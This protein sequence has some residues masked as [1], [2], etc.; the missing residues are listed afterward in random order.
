MPLFTIQIDHQFYIGYP[1]IVETGETQIFFSGC[2][3]RKNSVLKHYYRTT[4]F[5]I[6]SS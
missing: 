2:A 3:F 6:S 1:C 5:S 4:K